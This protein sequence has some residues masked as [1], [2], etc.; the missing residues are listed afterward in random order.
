VRG[1]AQATLSDRPGLSVVLI[2]LSHFESR[3]DQ[4]VTTLDG[5]NGL[6]SF[7]RSQGS[8]PQRAGPGGGKRSLGLQ[9]R[10]VGGVLSATS[11][12]AS[13]SIAERAEFLAQDEV[14]SLNGRPIAEY[15]QGSL[16]SLI[17]GSEPLRW[18]VKRGDEVVV[19]EVN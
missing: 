16:G 4:L 18:E 8:G 14:L 11:S 2:V 17:G 12:V 13:G 15:A 19:I 7:R 9:F 10:G 3:T 6:M 5:A 1:P